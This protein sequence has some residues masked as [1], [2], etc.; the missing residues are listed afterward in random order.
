MFVG[1]QYS[2]IKDH[3]K[4]FVGRQYSIIKDRWKVS[5]VWAAILYY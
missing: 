1:R 5:F 3:W 2:I 4:V